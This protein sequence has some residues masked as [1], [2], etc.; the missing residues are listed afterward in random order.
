MPFIDQISDMFHN[1]IPVFILINFILFIILIYLNREYIKK[2]FFKIDRK[3]WIFLIL[4]FIFALLI[5]IF[6]P[7]HAHIMYLDEPWYMYAGK[8]MLETGSQLDYDKSIGWPFILSI[9]FSIFGVNNYVAL[10]AST[11]FG[12]LTVF[13]MFFLT[14]LIT[15]RQDLSL[16]SAFIFS[17]FPIHIIWSAS[18]ETNVTSVFFIT[19]NLFFCFLYYQNQKNSL[20]WLSLI[21]LSFISQL[22]PENYIFP[23]L[24]IFG[25]ILYIKDF[26]KKIDFKFVLPFIILVILSLPN[27]IGVFDH[28]SSINWNESDSSGKITGDNWSFS[29]LINHSIDYGVP[30]FSYQNQSVIILI[31]LVIGFYYFLFQQEKDSLF[32]FIWFILLWIIYFASWPVGG[33]ERLYLSFYPIFSLFASYGVLWLINIYQRISQKYINLIYFFIVFVVFISSFS[34]MFNDKSLYSDESH[35]LETKIIEFAEKDIPSNCLI[36][37]LYETV[38]ESTTN[39]NVTTIDNF[40]KKNNI[41]ISNPDLDENH[42]IHFTLSNN[43]TSDKECY[44]EL[45]IK[46][47]NDSNSIEIYNGIVQQNKSLNFDFHIKEIPEGDSIINV[48]TYCKNTEIKCLLFFDDM[49]C[50]FFK[51]NKEKCY[52]IKDNY[53]LKPYK[54]YTE[55]KQT[56]GF[57][58]IFIKNNT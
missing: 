25:C 42:S 52:I 4:I 38:L 15:K 39:L 37:S 26:F 7:T 57:Y 21:S 32:L 5:R 34:Y 54:L 1:K 8:S 22:R 11:L 10:Y 44:S 23:L 2:I 28:L 9:F 45:V 14:F 31:L 51:T 6:V 43:D 18:A 35:I 12:S 3:T 47:K 40:I 49:M 17:L 56:Y 24:F 53:N 16:I 36:V 13:S 20:L 46:Y 29:N 19:L 33:Y 58:G 27:M 30:L 55:G 48:E 41:K 50:S